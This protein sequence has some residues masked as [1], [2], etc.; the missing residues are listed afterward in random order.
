MAMRSG[1]QSVSHSEAMLDV[2]VGPHS[3]PKGCSGVP[4]SS[5]PSV[6]SIPASPAVALASVGV[7]YLKYI[8]QSRACGVLTSLFS[9]SQLH[10]CNFGSCIYSFFKITC[11]GVFNR[12][13]VVHEIYFFGHYNFPSA[14]FKVDTFCVLSI[15]GIPKC[16]KVERYQGKWGA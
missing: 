2:Y 16:L 3:D 11:P 1:S 12:V 9:N 8:T 7:R 14:S 10:F 15:D 5:P 13:V 6:D 4:F